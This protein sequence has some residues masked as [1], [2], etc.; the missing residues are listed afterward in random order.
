MALQGNKPAV[1][2]YIYAALLALRKSYLNRH[3]AGLT[4]K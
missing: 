3:F 4:V 1:L 2:R